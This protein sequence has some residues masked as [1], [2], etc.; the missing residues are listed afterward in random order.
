LKVTERLI[1]AFLL[2]VV[3]VVIHDVSFASCWFKVLLR[4]SPTKPFGVDPTEPP[5]NSTKSTRTMFKS[6][7]S[8]KAAYKA[9]TSPYFHAYEIWTSMVT[10]APTTHSPPLQNGSPAARAGGGHTHEGVVDVPIRIDPT[11]RSSCLSE[12][13]RP[14]P[15]PLDLLNATSTSTAAT[16]S[17]GTEEVRG[18]LEIAVNSPA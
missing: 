12:W 11:A 4:D 3:V 18:A 10:A 17:G 15:L 16:V 2:S 9:T 13:P 8:K 6:S 1:F 5:S 7:N 14:A